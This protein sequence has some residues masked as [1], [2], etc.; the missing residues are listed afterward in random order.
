M[1][2]SK[3]SRHQLLKLYLHFMPLLK[4]AGIK[5]IAFYG[6]LLGI[7]R[8]KDFIINDDD[9]D[10]IIHNK[11][12]PKLHNLIHREKIKTGVSNNDII[13][14]YYNNIGPFDIYIYYDKGDD[15]IL[16]WDGNLLYSKKEMFPLKNI[17]FNGYDLYIPNNSKEILRQTYG[18]NYMIPIKKSSYSWWDIH[19]V[20]RHKE[21]KIESFLD[22]KNK[23]YNKCK[24]EIIIIIVFIIIC[25]LLVILNSLF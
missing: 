3:K 19:Q 1:A 23:N 2:G 20:R 7:I 24:P 11:D 9:I 16:K 8:E 17:N 25:L 5:V 15:I 4:K 13:A 10:I 21:D 14:L 12:L 18:D 6:T 22:Y